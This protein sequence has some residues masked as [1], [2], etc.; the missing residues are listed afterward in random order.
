MMGAGAI[1]ERVDV[2]QAG[3]RARQRVLSSLRAVVLAAVAAALAWYLAHHVLG[4][5]Q[6]FFAPIAA[7]ISLSTS[8]IQR[9]RRIAQ[10]V[11]GVLL[12]IVIGEGL[13]GLLGGSTAALGAIVLVT[14]IVALAAGAGFFGE[15]M[16]PSSACWRR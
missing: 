6:P 12:G 10:M 13:Y 8:Q 1:R 5:P 7:A 3:R 16:M 4:H 15:G 9:S 11:V 2:T 14:M